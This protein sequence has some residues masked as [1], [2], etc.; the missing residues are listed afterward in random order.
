MLA[1][2][3]FIIVVTANIVIAIAITEKLTTP[4]KEMP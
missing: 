2:P 1:M 3:N 4:S